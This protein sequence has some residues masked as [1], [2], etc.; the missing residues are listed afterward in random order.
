[1][2]ELCRTQRVKVGKLSSKPGSADFFVLFAA[3]SKAVGVK[4]VVGAE[5][6]R[7]LAKAIAAAKFKAPLPDDAPTKLVRRGVMVCESY[8]LGCHFT[9]FTL[10]VVKS[11]N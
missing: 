6:L 3:N 7:P 9:L 8:N 2:E 1:M 11:V 5:E 10:D 4:F